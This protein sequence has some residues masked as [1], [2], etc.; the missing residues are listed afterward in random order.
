MCV[1]HNATIWSEKGMQLCKNSVE[2]SKSSSVMPAVHMHNFD[3]IYTLCRDDPPKNGSHIEHARNVCVRSVN[4]L[5][6][7][8]QALSNGSMGNT[9]I[10]FAGKHC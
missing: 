9:T 2:S 7:P 3:S 8:Y 4:G 5:H 6:E 10:N 1:Y